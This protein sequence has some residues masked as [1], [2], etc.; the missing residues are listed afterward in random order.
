MGFYGYDLMGDMAFGGGMHESLFSHRTVF[1]M[2]DAPV[3]C[4]KGFTMLQ[5][6]EDTKGYWAAL[7]GGLKL[8]AWFGHIPWFALTLMHLM[9]PSPEQQRFIE[10]SFEAYGKRKDE[11]PKTRDIFYY[12]L[13]QGEDTKAAVKLKDDDLAADAMLI[14][15]AGQL[16][17]SLAVEI[18]SR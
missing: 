18:H 4:Y 7:K 5:D 3:L 1:A 2:A 16:S 9:P 14:I 8:A 11:V 10:F 15:A 17:V 6:G 12:L 13:G